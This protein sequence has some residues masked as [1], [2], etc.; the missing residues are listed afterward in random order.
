MRAVRELVLVLAALG[1]VLAGC[2]PP[3]LAGPPLQPMSTTE[4][5]GARCAGGQAPS[6]PDLM[7]WDPASR[8]GL[9]G[10]RKQGI[11]AVNYEVKGCDV[12]LEVLNNCVGQGQYQYVPYWESDHK[13]ARNEGEL[14]AQ[15]PLGAGE[16]A[17]KLQGNRALRT[18]YMLVGIAQIP[19]G[20][21][22]SSSALIGDCSRATHVVSRMYLGGFAMAVGEQRSLES[23]ASLFGTASAGARNEASFER[24]QPAGDA[25][26]CE[27]SRQSQKETPGCSVPLRLTLLPLEQLR[28]CSEPAECDARCQA[29]DLWA[30]MTLGNLY[31]DATPPKA[32]PAISAYQQAC[33]RGLAVGCATLGHR[34][35]RGDLVQMNLPKAFELLNQ[36]C[37]ADVS[38]G[39]GLLGTMYEAGTGVSQDPV[40][41]LSL[42]QKA[43]EEG[44]EDACK[45]GEPMFQA[46]CQGDS[47]DNAS[48]C[49]TLSRMYY[50]GHGVARNPKQALAILEGACDRG[51]TEPCLEL[52]ARYTRAEGAERNGSK[53]AGIFKK[54]CDNG[55]GAGCLN[56]GSI[57]FEGDGVPRDLGKAL[58]L[59]DRAC[60][61][62]N[63]DGCNNLGAMYED[64]KG[65]KADLPRALEL[66][67]NACDG[68]SAEACGNLASLYETG[69]GCEKDVPHALKLYEQACG[70][71]LE[72]ACGAWHRLSP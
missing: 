27:H 11:V 2:N 57:Y 55:E 66:Y 67:R 25:Q 30:C 61:R 72:A 63:W 18:D 8:A 4:A 17:S 40:R 24:F 68:S 36:A 15:L 51:L 41:A 69:K 3:N 65:V 62:G 56:L 38:W 23:S 33:D 64:G 28:A 9:V 14:Y 58:G 37:A 44:D 26:S 29:N 39:C 21:R 48:S 43:C 16:L 53:A 20:V 59:F 1:P 46:A 42:F 45:H 70:A 31:E 7:A 22:F 49:E 19:A 71:G 52:G 10:L 50:E 34:Y 35:Y 60:D 13:V 6:E 32:A 5:F 47:E 54:L 12:H